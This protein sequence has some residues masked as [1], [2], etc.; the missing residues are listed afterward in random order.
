MNCIYD[1]Q[2]ANTEANTTSGDI[3][4]PGWRKVEGIRMLV[5]DE[6][7]DP[8]LAYTDGKAALFSWGGTTLT[9][10]EQTG[11]TL[12]M[13]VGERYQFTLKIT[14]WRDGDLPATLS[15]T[16]GEEAKTQNTNVS[17]RVK[18]VEGNPFSEL[19][20][21]FTPTTDNPVLKIYA[22]KHF[23]IA[24]LNLM[25]A[26]ALLGDVNGDDNVNVADVTALVNILLSTGEKHAA[27]NVDGNDTIDIN[28]VKALLQIIL[29][30]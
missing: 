25:K 9:Y 5:K 21:I 7:T 10:G 14:G 3:N 29:T 11:Y 27:A 2:F 6:A 19:E 30:E 4:L 22:D 26:P 23:V 13:N 20:F 18:D 1:G 12:P 28:D 16:L 15:V 8:G 17:G 24:D